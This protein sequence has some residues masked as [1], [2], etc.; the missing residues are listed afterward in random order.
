MHTS[1]LRTI[2]IAVVVVTLAGQAV[3]GQQQ[4]LFTQYM[5]NGLAVNP[6]YA[7]SQ[8]SLPPLPTGDIPS[9]SLVS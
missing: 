3:F 8:E 2:W 4:A 5:F 1:L 9:I 6:A 7:G